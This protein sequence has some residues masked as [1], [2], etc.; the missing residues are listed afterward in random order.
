[1]DPSLCFSPRTHPHTHSLPPP[2]V[3]RSLPLRGHFVHHR[4]AFSSP[5]PPPL[6]SAPIVFWPSGESLI[7]SAL[8]I[9]TLFSSVG[10]QHLF[11]ASL[12]HHHPSHQH[13]HTHSYKTPFSTLTRLHPQRAFSSEKTEVPYVTVITDQ[14]CVILGPATEAFDVLQ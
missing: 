7:L 4:G 10:C 6:F 13:I 11:N 5:P 12:W 1:M 14:P 8:Q 3:V 9:S 2:H